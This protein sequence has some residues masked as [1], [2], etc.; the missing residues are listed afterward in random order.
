MAKTVTH[1]YIPS[2]GM[3]VKTFAQLRKMFPQKL[4]AETL[5]KLSIALGNESQVITVIRF[6]GFIDE[7]G[8]K[9]KDAN[10]V[11]LKHDETQFAKALEIVVRKAYEALFDTLGNQAWTTERSTLIGFFR[12]NDETSELVATRQAI[13]FET[14]SSL[15]G[16]GEAVKP[17]ASKGT[18][19]NT[20]SAKKKSKS[21]K[22]GDSKKLTD[23]TPGGS[24]DLGL[25]VRIEVNLPAQGDQETYDRIFKS[26]REN[27]LNG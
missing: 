7:H 2:G 17:R 11:F 6:L 4:D 1:P 21:D 20:G 18:S 9:T 14:L 25:S 26:I 19:A 24:R 3:I 23:S 5:R 27:L 10:S 8:A 15:S 16:H 13:A 12:V 22:Q